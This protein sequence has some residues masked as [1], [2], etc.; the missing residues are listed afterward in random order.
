MIKAGAGDGIKTLAPRWV[1]G[2]DERTGGGGP[3]DMT[4]PERGRRGLWAGRAGMAGWP[5]L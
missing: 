3:G 5:E 2:S 4:G 1:D